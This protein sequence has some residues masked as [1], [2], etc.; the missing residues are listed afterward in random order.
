MNTYHK[1]VIKWWIPVIFFIGNPS[2]CRP[3]RWQFFH[4]FLTPRIRMACLFISRVSHAVAVDSSRMTASSSASWS[5]FSPPSN[6]VNGHVSTMWFMVCRWPQ[7]HEGDWARPICVR[8]STT[9]ALTGPE[10]VHQRPCITR[11]IE[12]SLSDSRVGNKCG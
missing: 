8:V 6:F 1:I 11:E 9:W 2:Q 3:T 5:R 4:Q 10:T 7:S 12:T